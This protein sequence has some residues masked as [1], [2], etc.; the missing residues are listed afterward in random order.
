[1]RPYE[2]TAHKPLIIF[3]SQSAE[4]KDPVPAK[5]GPMDKRNLGARRVTSA[6][7]RKNN[8]LSELKNVNIVGYPVQNFGS[9]K[10]QP[11]NRFHENLSICHLGD[12][13]PNSNEKM[14]LRATRVLKAKK[15]A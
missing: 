8:K 4:V 2:I 6:E 14:F 10:N 13:T 5:S 3:P 15:T 9:P 11:R 12:F 1:M 7:Y